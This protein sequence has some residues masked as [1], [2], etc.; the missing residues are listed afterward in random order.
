MAFVTTEPALMAMATGDLQLIGSETAA[1][2][3]DVA[4]PMFVTSRCGRGCA[5]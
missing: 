4:S 2:K 5:D 1:G 3:A